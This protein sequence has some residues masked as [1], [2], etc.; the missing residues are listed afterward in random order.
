MSIHWSKYLCIPLFALLL[1]ISQSGVSYAQGGSQVQQQCLAVLDNLKA[2]IADCDDMNSNFACYAS[3][4]ADVLP[5]QYRFQGVRDRRPLKVLENVNTDNNGVV[6]LNLLPEGVTSPVKAMM[7]GNGTLNAAEPGQNSFI[8]TI[9]NPAELCEVTPPGLVLHT[10]TGERGVVKL[11]GVTIELRS[12]AFVTIEPDDLMTIVNLEGQVSVTIGGVTQILPVGFQ[13]RTTATGTPGFAIGAP[14]SSRYSSSVALRAVTDDA[15]E[16]IK[17][18]RNTNETAAACV[19]EIAFGQTITSQTITHPGHE[20]IYTFVVN[21][22]ETF[23]VEMNAE[24]GQLDPW[25]DIRGPSGLLLAYNNNVQATDS[26]ICGETLPAPGQYTIIA[27]SNSNE[28]AGTFTISLSQGNTCPQ[29]PLPACHV[30]AGESVVVYEGPNVNAAVIDQLSPRAEMQ[31]LTTNQE[32]TR[33]QVRAFTA[34]GATLE[35]WVTSQPQLVQCEPQHVE[36]MPEPQAPTPDPAPPPIPTPPPTD[37]V[38]PAGPDDVIAASCDTYRG[39]NPPPG[40]ED[41]ALPNGDQEEEE[42]SG[43]PI[44]PPPDKSGAFGGP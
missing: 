13:T 35:G 19:Q 16:G 25:L 14:Q 39:L 40:C 42:S 18:V 30:R 27:R 23:S 15:A 12:T 43:Q 9:D 22:G 24:D 6:L 5:V 1:W 20:C 36:R 28:S 7:F 8:M 21:E 26:A 37:P 10:E 33:H 41:T 34:N 38:D 4:N 32:R 2:A 3:T 29:Q 31:Y 11:N 44:D 17:R